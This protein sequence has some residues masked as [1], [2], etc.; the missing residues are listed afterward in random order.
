MNRAIALSLF[1]QVRFCL[2]SFGLV[3]SGSCCAVLVLPDAKN[4][5]TYTCPNFERNGD[6]DRGKD[7]DEDDS[8]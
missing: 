8:G 4:T 7:R 6:R 3:R 5:S 2:V 1:W